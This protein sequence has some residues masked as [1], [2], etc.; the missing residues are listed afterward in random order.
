MKATITTA[1]I[2]FRF[3]FNDDSTMEATYY[4]KSEISNEDAIA[5]AW[6]IMATDNFDRHLITK[7]IMIKAFLIEIQ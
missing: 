3:Y 6:E 5:K 4:G 7:T 2:S 1:K